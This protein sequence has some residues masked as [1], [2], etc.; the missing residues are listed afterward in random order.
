MTGE[1]NRGH[2][3]ILLFCKAHARSSESSLPKMA[4]NSGG[5]RHAKFLQNMSSTA[6]PEVSLSV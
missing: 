1:C 6:T 4:V 5:A 3:L 2:L